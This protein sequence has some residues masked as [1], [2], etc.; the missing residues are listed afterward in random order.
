MNPTGTERLPGTNVRQPSLSTGRYSPKS[1]SA[2]LAITIATSLFLC[3]TLGS[4]TGFFINPTISSIFI[5]P[6]SATV[7]VNNTVQLTAT[8]RFS[9]GSS[10]SISGSDVGWSSSSDTVA[11]I[12]AGGLVRAISNGTATMTVTDQGI[13]A[14]ANVTVTPANVTSLVI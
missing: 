5:S 3:V 9:D 8:A 2:R 6:A 14:T 12:T 10:S 13:S 11:S 4:C 1:W 7:A